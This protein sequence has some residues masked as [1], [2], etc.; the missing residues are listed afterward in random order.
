[1]FAPGMTVWAPSLTNSLSGSSASSM[2]LE[3]L[4]HKLS[5]TVECNLQLRHYGTDQSTLSGEVLGRKVGS[6]N[7]HLPELPQWIY[8]LF[9]FFLS[10]PRLIFSHIHLHLIFIVYLRH[11]SYTAVVTYTVFILDTIS[12]SWKWKMKNLMLFSFLVLFLETKAALTPVQSH[13]S[14]SGG[15]HT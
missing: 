8:T 12:T 6:M 3:K 5:R 10:E 15:G 14:L 13:I 11:C 2:D 1:M 7:V 4:W 9:D